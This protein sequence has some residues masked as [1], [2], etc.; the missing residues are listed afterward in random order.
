MAYYDIGQG[1]AVTLLHGFTQTATSW[2]EVVDLMPQTQRW[3]IPDL[4]GHGR[5]RA[6]GPH[7]LDAC[8]DDLIKL[9]DSLSAREVHL[10]GYSM[11]GRLALHLATTYPQRLLSLTTLGCGAW[12]DDSARE[13]RLESDLAMADQID[14]LGIDLFVD[15][16]LS[17][18]L[19]AGLKRRGPDFEARTRAQ[20]LVNR[21]EG[22]A[23][24]LREMG[25]GAQPAPN[26]AALATIKCPSL[27]LA[28]E[29][30]ARYVEAAAG[31]AKAVPGGRFGVLPG[32][33][34]AAHLEDPNE[35]ARVLAT[36]LSDR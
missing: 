27:F 13:A 34:H 4:R 20:R 22:V 29:L 6:S 24:S 8:V 1:P 11:G 17:L 9:W 14:D 5:S 2:L 21:P 31:L 32:V 35:F 18:P 16:W 36:H 26:R 3:L 23:R 19:F 28:G 15:R 33:G 25:P 7:T 30:D 10:V 12:L